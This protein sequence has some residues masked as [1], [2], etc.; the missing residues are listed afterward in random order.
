MPAD[1]AL[2][3]PGWLIQHRRL[4]GYLVVRD[5]LLYLMQDKAQATRFPSAESAEEQRRALA[6]DIGASFASSYDIV[7][8][9]P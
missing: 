7:E 3:A 6:T 5:G 4:G 9:T 8:D 2:P 1:T